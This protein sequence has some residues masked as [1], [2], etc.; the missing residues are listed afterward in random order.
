[1]SQAYSSG[2]LARATGITIRAIRFYEE[3]GLLDAGE[4]PPGRR[5]RYGEADLERLRLI[6]DLRELG[7][8][9]SEVRSLLALRGGCRTAAEFATRFREVVAQQL[10]E[11]RR[12][13]ATLRRLKRELSESLALVEHR[14]HAPGEAGACPCTVAGSAQATRLVRVLAGHDG[15]CAAAAGAAVDGARLRASA[16]EG[17]G[18]L[19]PRML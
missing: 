18:P 19:R 7:L 5:R 17:T 16:A 8:P 4:G 6:G 12:R 1:M 15:D 13:L 14:L 9:I 2:D 3:E 11:T 10:E